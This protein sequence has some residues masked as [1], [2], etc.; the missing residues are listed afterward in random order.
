MNRR[1]AD[2][3]REVGQLEAVEGV[4]ERRRRAAQTAALLGETREAV[5][6]LEGDARAVGGGEDEAAL[7]GAHV[8]AEDGL[9]RC[10]SE[11]LVTVCYS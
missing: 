1:S 11:Q 10:F 2:E 4:G 6:R 8:V 9:A 3:L 5:R 7:C